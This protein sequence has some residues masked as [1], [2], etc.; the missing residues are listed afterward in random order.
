MTINLI[1]DE[2]SKFK[3]NRIMGTSDQKIQIEISRKQ[4]IGLSQEREF[5]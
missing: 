2:I 1:P 5:V 4:E 3:R